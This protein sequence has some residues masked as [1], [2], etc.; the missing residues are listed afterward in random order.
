MSHIY[1]IIKTPKSYLPLIFLFIL[2]DEICNNYFFTVYVEKTKIE[3]FV[4]NTSFLL[5][6]IF[7]SPIQAGLSDEYCRKN[8]LVFSLS[9]SLLSLILMFFYENN[10]LFGKVFSISLATFIKGALGNTLPLAWAAL[11]DTQNKNFRFSMGV[12][13]SAIALGYLA[14]VTIN[15]YF[16][17]VNLIIIILLFLISLVNCIKLFLDIRDKKNLK[18]ISLEIGQKVVESEIVL[19]QQ[20]SLIKKLINICSFKVLYNKF[21]VPIRSRNGLYMFFYWETSFYCIHML[22]VD[23]KLKEFAG[24]TTVMILGYLLGITFLYFLKN[25]DEVLLKVGYIISSVALL[26]IFIFYPFLVNIIYVIY[27]S[28]FL[29]SFAAAFLTPSLFSLLSK[30][31]EV[32]DLGK[33]YGLADSTDTLGFLVASIIDLIYH[34]LG[35]GPIFIVFV[36]FTIFN[37]S[38]VPYAK[39]IKSIP[40]RVL[41]FE[42]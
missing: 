33:I 41:A 25:K 15:D 37:I 3:T 23:L 22:D 20:N 16:K 31:C 34:A 11:A 40:N 35:L 36:S 6:Q 12:A 18:H 38:W 4:F 19:K 32:H 7:N 9:A 30:E 2:I 29:Y 39:F 26:P 5:L 17:E 13:T 27:F 8:S 10:I 28:C 14:L 1:S 24:V 42:E 21:L